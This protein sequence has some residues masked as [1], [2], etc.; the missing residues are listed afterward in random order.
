MVKTL[1]NKYPWAARIIAFT[2]LIVV[3]GASALGIWL[4]AYRAGIKSCAA[5][6]NKELQ[7]QIRDDQKD[8]DKLRVACRGSRIYECMYDSGGEWNFLPDIKIPFTGSD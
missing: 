7:E 1:V 4:S 3:L 5:G 8:D 6:A 2:A